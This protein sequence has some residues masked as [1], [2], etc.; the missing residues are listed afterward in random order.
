MGNPLWI[1]SACLLFAL[2]GVLPLLWMRWAEG[3][4]WRPAEIESTAWQGWTRRG[5]ARPGRTGEEQ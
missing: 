1:A 2:I 5:A 3:R 4:N